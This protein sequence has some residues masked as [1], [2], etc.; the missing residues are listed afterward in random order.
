MLCGQ[1]KR[2]SRGS[3]N[4][5]ARGAQIGILFFFT[6][7]TNLRYIIVFNGSPHNQKCPYDTRWWCV[8]KNR[9][10]FSLQFS[11]QSSRMCF[12]HSPFLEWLLI[13]HFEVPLGSAFWVPTERPIEKCPNFQ[14]L[15]DYFAIKFE[16]RRDGYNYFSPWGCQKTPIIF[17]RTS[18]MPI[19]IDTTRNRG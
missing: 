3:I 16:K 12:N 17:N 7:R 18:I 13:V 9:L 8:C 6:I 10:P 5:G 19:I 11:R 14:S 2:P 1:H 4:S 15:V